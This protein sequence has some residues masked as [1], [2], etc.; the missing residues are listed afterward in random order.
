MQIVALSWLVLDLTGSATALG[1]VALAQYLPLLVLGVPAGVRLDRM[2]RYR[3]CMIAQCCFALLSVAIGS[4]V[5]A[6]AV[7][8]PVVVVYSS[9]SGLV[10]VIDQPL[11]TAMVTDLVAPGALLTAIGYNNAM[12]A[13]SRVLGPILSGIVI[14][15][16]GVGAVFAVNAGSY[17]VMIVALAAMRRSEL[18]QRVSA[19][20]GP[21]QMREGLSYVIGNK[22]V[23]AILAFVAVFMGF[24]WEFD[25]MLPSV[26]RDRFDGDATTLAWLSAAVGFGCT[27]GAVCI[28]RLKEPSSYV[29]AS[30]V[31]AC[32]WLWLGGA[33]LVA[34]AGGMGRRRSVCHERADLGQRGLHL[35]TDARM[36]G[37]V[38]AMW[39]ISTVARE[40]SVLLPS[41]C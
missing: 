24:V 22:S 16:S 8:L 21:G 37:R 17:A 13:T 39:S 6:G 32:S 4:L 41:V 12:F 31:A 14:A 5:A 11:R 35:D 28:G 10:S 29:F 33:D 19:E 18:R 38:M 9:L 2:N 30:L 40:R 34:C 3:L 20:A 36:R 15:R 1:L 26:A 7:S 27:V 25:V 23:L